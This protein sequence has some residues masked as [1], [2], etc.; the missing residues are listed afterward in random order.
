MT[1][2]PAAN[3]PVQLQHT[4]RGPVQVQL[5]PVEASPLSPTTQIMNSSSSF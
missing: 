5:A 2:V 4:F 1:M 3:G